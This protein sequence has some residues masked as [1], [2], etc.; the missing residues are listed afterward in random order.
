[1]VVILHG[2]ALVLYVA[3]TGILIGS[4]VQGRR[5]VSRGGEATLAGG[6]LAHGVGLGA[7]VLRFQELPLVGLAPS[8]SVLSFLIGA[9]LLGMAAYREARTIGLILA[10]LIS[11]LLAV[12]LLLG[13]A[14]AGEAFAFR[15]PWFHLHVFLAFV[16]Y[17]GL[18]VS[19]AA[20]LL[21]LLQFRELKGKHFGRM[22]RFFPALD[23]LDL[24]GRRS[25]AVGFSSLSLA[26]VLGWAWTV[27]FQHSFAFGDP[28]VAWAVLTWLTFA[29]V[30]A[31]RRGGSRRSRR[32]ALASVVGFAV[33]VLVYVILRLSVTGGALFL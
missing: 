19:F 30:L 6:V 4:L 22:F 21:Y 3:A 13:I 20:G 8:L 25:L 1:M 27:R 33:V 7:Y 17:A 10:P 16:G 31:A 18:A 24:V 2:L 15:G 14:P 11:T 5:T 23:T 32:G 12:A 29:A 28:K 9:V 26:L